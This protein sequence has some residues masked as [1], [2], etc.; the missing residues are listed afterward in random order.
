[1]EILHRTITGMTSRKCEKLIS[2][3]MSGEIAGVTKVKTDRPS[4]K[5]KIRT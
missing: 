1:M 5:T 4:G 2:K 3:G